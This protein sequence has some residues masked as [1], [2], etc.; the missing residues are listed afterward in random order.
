MNRTGYPLCAQ[1]PFQ[2]RQGQVRK[3]MNAQ[4]RIQQ[5][6]LHMSPFFPR[7]YTWYSTVFPII[8]TGAI[9]PHGASSSNVHMLFDTPRAVSMI[10][11]A[12]GQ[13]V[14]SPSRMFRFSMGVQSQ[15]IGRQLIRWFSGAV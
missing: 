13:P 14:P 15:G 3:F 6:D 1:I 10:R 11:M 4:W 9:V 8:E 2:H 7:E 5:A 12:S